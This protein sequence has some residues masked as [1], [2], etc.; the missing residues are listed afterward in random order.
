M[1]KL[2][3]MQNKELYPEDPEPNHTEEELDTLHDLTIE[4]KLERQL[5]RDEADEH[6]SKSRWPI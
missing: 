1:T 6:F 2:E 5:A 4:Q 3:I